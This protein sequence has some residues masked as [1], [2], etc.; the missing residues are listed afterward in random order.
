MVAQEASGVMVV[1]MLW[2]QGPMCE[3]LAWE[4]EVEG[5]MREMVRLVEEGELDL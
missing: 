4:L 2:Q 1:A 3:V 5:A